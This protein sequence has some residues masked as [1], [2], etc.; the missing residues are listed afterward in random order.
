[1]HEELVYGCGFARQTR[2]PQERAPTVSPLQKVVLYELIPQPQ[3]TLGL[4]ILLSFL[5]GVISIIKDVC[6]TRS[7]HTN[8]LPLVLEPGELAVPLPVTVEE[9]GAKIFEGNP[10]RKTMRRIK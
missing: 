2:T 3:F 4:G 1:M 7:R 9:G 8:P 6:S 5:L 10:Y